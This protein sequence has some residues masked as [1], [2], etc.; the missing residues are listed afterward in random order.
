MG[1]VHVDLQRWK[2]AVPTHHPDHL[3]LLSMIQIADSI[4]C[5]DI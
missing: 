4:M 3:Q 2:A 5:R 1:F